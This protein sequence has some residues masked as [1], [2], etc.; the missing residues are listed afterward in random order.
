MERGDL[1]N[2]WRALLDE[3]LS[4]GYACMVSSLMYYNLKMLPA[5]QTTELSFLFVVLDEL[6]F[7]GTAE[8]LPRET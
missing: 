8:W 6:L 7:G 5:L 3:F 4:L 1:A 2:I